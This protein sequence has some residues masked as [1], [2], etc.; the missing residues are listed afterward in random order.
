MQGRTVLIWVGTVAPSTGAVTADPVL[1]FNGQVDQGV[2]SVGLGTRSLALDCVSIWEY[3]FDDA[4]GVRLT[5]AYHQAA[6]PGELGMEFVTAVQRQ[7]PWGADTPRP[8]VVADALT[9]RELFK[10]AR[11]QRRV[12]DRPRSSDTFSG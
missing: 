5:N 11:S 10:A 12:W 9:I 7:L 4:Q 2:W 1:V 8:Q 6:W 3:L